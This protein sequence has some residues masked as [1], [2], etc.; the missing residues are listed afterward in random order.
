[1][2]STVRYQIAT[3]SGTIQ[4]F[5]VDENEGTETVIARAKAILTRRSGPLPFGSESWE[6][7]SREPAGG[8]EDE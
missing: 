4:V 7:I 5:D 2:T 1:M 3:Y 6:E 8:G